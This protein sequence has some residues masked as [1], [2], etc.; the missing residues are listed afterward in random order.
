M[1][2]APSA[3]SAADARRSLASSAPLRY[4]CGN[5]VHSFLGDGAAVECRFP[6]GQD[7]IS[8]SS[9]FNLA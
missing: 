1:S 8:A 5:S 6:H 9:F 2:A 4:L 7:G 3:F